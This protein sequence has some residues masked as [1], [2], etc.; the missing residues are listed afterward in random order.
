MPG[1]PLIP[2]N[3]KRWALC[4]QL[5]ISDLWPHHAH[6]ARQRA[7]LTSRQGRDV[8]PRGIPSLPALHRNPL[9]QMVYL[10]PAIESARN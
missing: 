2:G 9:G 1:S 10:T 4:H 6:C 8:T 3:W 7:D 5:V